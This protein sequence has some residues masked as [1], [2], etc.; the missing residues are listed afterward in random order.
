V[1]KDLVKMT[2]WIRRDQNEAIRQISEREERSIAVLVRKALD[3]LIE[4]RRK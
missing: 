4:E 1:K 3:W 2:V